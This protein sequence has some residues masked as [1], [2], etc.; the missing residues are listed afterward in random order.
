MARG[1]AKRIRTALMLLVALIF[2]ATT[3]GPAQ[4]GTFQIP[5]KGNKKIK[6]GVL[7]LLSAI[8]VAALANNWYRKH[9]KDRGWDLQV[10][11]IALD[12]AKGQSTMEN[13]IMAGYDG[14]LVNWVD[15]KYIDQQVMKA[16]KRGIPVQGA[17][18]GNMVPGV[19]S[20][21]IAPDMG[22]GALSSL[23]LVS[24]L[25]E[26][27]KILVYYYP[28][29][30][31]ELFRFNAA[32]VTF[33]MYKIKIAQELHSSGGGDPSQACYEAMRNAILA[34]TK[35][36]IKGVWTS[37]DGLGIPSARAAMDM[38]RKDIVVVTCNDTPNTYK[39]L[40]ELPTLHATSGAIWEIQ[41]WTGRLF[42]NLD[43][44]FAGKPF[45][46]EEVWFP[47]P[48]LVTKDNLPPP[49]YY[50]N[51]CGYKGRP[52]DFKVR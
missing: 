4:A 46:D 10:F 32:K 19:I 14:I 13:M 15:F 50:Y 49:G 23:Y 25:H 11:D 30:S 42:R 16:Y 28:I 40:R 12:I 27:D 18:C 26:G 37:W 48:N 45:Q 8:E 52:P 39:E 20:H 24:K 7:D 47:M 35:K 5:P 17:A 1:I 33:D 41:E 31:T 36:E 38:G 29:V 34:D 43:K 2:V 6:L 3:L 44:I 9:A 22:I 51:P 21:C